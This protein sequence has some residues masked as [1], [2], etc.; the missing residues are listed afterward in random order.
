MSTGAKNMK[1]RLDALGVANNESG[2]QNKKTRPDAL[3]TNENV[4][5]NAKHEN[6]TRRRRYRRK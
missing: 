2:A 5:E 1:T 4:P 3:H 6:G